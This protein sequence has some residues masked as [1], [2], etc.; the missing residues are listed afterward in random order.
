MFGNCFLMSLQ[1][2]EDKV[3]EIKIPSVDEVVQFLNTPTKERTREDIEYIARYLKNL[4]F[5]KTFEDEGNGEVIEQCGKE[6]KV[7]FSKN[8]DHVITHGEFGQ[9]FYVLLKGTV[10]VYIPENKTLHLN[11]KEFLE[12]AVPKRRFI[13]AVN[14]QELRLPVY[15][16]I[17]EFDEE[18]KIDMEKLRTFLYRNN[19]YNKKTI[20]RYIGNRNRN[21][22]EF[23]FFKRVAELGAGFE[24]GG[25]A[26]TSGKPR[27]ATI[28]AETDLIL[29]TLD[30]RPFDMTL[31]KHKKKKED[32]DVAKISRFSVFKPYSKTFKIKVLKYV[33]PLTL[34]KGQY[35]FK[36]NDRPD[37]IY[38]LVEGSITYMKE[39]Q[40]LRS[41]DRDLVF[42]KNT[43]S[44]EL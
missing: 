36:E 24:F 31:R 14:K 6:M 21:D 25:D 18:G 35:L 23:D 4:K 32:Q 28:A 2:N 12:F 19:Q 38:L 15:V 11:Q 3:E 37:L 43:I 29:A 5:F 42:T 26:L 39:F 41:E 7:Q 40:I 16:D 20:M 8:E 1:K 22:Y 33:K 10:G 17:F 44:S 30:K 13:K 9:T 34:K 27:N